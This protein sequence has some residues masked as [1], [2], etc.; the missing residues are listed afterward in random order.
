MHRR[1]IAV[2]NSPPHAT[3]AV[4]RLKDRGVPAAAIST[5]VADSVA[6]QAM[7]QTERS[8]AADGAAKGS[9]VGAG[10]G[11]SAA[12]AAAA[13]G[14]LATGPLGVAIAAAGAGAAAGGLLGALMGFGIPEKDG[15]LLVDRF[16]QGAV[17]VAI[18]CHDF[19][20][21]EIAADVLGAGD[22]AQ[23]L[24]IDNPSPADQIR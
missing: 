2:F 7:L 19:A 12:I 16:T 11:A 13:L 20:V 5:V 1:L 3:N 10:A 22:P 4:Q 6:G 17:M 14:V 18:D 9:A 8:H 24:R 15:E 23:V 21:E